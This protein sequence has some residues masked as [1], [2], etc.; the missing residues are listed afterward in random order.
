MSTCSLQI[1]ETIG[2]RPTMPKNHPGRCCIFQRWAPNP[3]AMNWGE[4]TACLLQMNWWSLRTNNQFKLKKTV[5]QLPIDSEEFTQ[6]STIS[7]WKAERKMSTCNQ[8]I[9]IGNT[10]MSTDYAQQS[11]SAGRHCPADEAFVQP[12]PSRPQLLGAVQCRSDHQ[13]VRVTYYARGL[14]PWKIIRWLCCWLLHPPTC[15]LW[16]WFSWSSC[17][18]GRQACIIHACCGVTVRFECDGRNTILDKCNINCG[19]WR[20]H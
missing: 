10:R 15:S 12:N 4:P 9:Y 16:S 11:I 20:Q 3:A 14:A 17:W 7:S 6:H 19:L 2:S 1:L 18:G 13:C 5:G 8:L